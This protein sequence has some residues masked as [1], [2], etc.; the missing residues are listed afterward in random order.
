MAVAARL[1]VRAGLVPPTVARRQVNLLKAVGLPVTLRGL[2]PRIVLNSLKMDKKT[3]QGKVRFVLTPRIGHA[4]VYEGFGSAD[5]VGA[6][7]E[8][9]PAASGAACANDH[10][11]GQS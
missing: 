10:K 2:S 1:G 11:E 3:R 6:I 5:I 8:C 9:R 4:S 7:T